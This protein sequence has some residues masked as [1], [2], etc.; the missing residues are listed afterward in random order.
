MDEIEG[1]EGAERVKRSYAGP[2]AK[3]GNIRTLEQALRLEDVG[4]TTAEEIRQQTGWFR[5]MD[6]KWRFEISDRDMEVDT[7]GKFHSNPDVRR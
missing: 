5:D 7:T 3:T 6:G 2:K 1:V 4:K